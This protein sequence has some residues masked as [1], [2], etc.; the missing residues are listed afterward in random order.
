M[1]PS[2]KWAAVKLRTEVWIFRSSHP[3]VFL[4]NGVLKI[5]GKFTGENPCRSVFSITLLCNFIVITFRHGCSPVNLLHIFRILF[6]KN[7]SRRLPLI[8]VNFVLNCHYH[9]NNQLSCQKI[10]LGIYHSLC[11]IIYHDLCFH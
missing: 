7:T 9:I 8:F 11:F 6:P 2:F 5:C 3:E 1:E 10:I 4:E